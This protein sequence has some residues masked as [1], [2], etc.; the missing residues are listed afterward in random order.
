MA[1]HVT[2]S[3]KRPGGLKESIHCSFVVEILYWFENGRE[4]K[5][6]VGFGQFTL[7][8]GEGIP[9]R[10][11]GLEWYCASVRVLSI[12]WLHV[13]NVLL[14]LESIWAIIY[15]THI[16]MST[17]IKTDMISFSFTMFS[18][19]LSSFFFKGSNFRSVSSKESVLL[20]SL[21]IFC[22]CFFL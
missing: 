11:L 8:N 5:A 15:I 14:Y 18:S 7:L 3:M 12:R 2:V 1:K 10:S 22:S 17:L 16:A 9:V 20:F 6:E 19:I 13:L 4:I 21:I